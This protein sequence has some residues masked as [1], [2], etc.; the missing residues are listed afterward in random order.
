MSQEEPSDR[1]PDPW[2]LRMAGH[3]Q[4]NLVVTECLKTQIRLT[5]LI[6]YFLICSWSWIPTHPLTVEHFILLFAEDAFLFSEEYFE[7]MCVCLQAVE[8]NNAS[9]LAEI[10]PKLVRHNFCLC[11]QLS[12][13]FKLHM[14]HFFFYVFCNFLSMNVRVLKFHIWIPYEKMVDPYFFPSP[15]DT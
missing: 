3:A 2:P 7:A 15:A 12:K 13:C 5:L 9:L 4:L 6:W 10:N 1:K 14:S 8:E 11:P